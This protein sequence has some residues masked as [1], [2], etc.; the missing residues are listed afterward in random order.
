MLDIT[1]IRRRLQDRNLA[2]V[3]RR[4]G[5]TRAHL[6]NMYN[7]KT[8][9]SYKMLKLLSDY[10]EGKDFPQPDQSRS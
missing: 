6:S 5:F 8:D 2:E 10:L 1:E 4:I 9:G 7:G 3:A